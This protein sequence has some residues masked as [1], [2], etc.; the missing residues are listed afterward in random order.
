[1]L[2]VQLPV[3]GEGEEADLEAL[4]DTD[5]ASALTENY[6]R[7]APSAGQRQR[8]WRRQR[9]APLGHAPERRQDPKKQK[10]R[11]NNNNNSN[12][13]NN[14]KTVRSYLLECPSTRISQSL[15]TRPPRI[16]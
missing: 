16:R 8:V 6:R 12:N 9:A 7:F 2:T 3:P 15:D 10:G 11:N 14:F 5:I 1:M 4:E 13:H